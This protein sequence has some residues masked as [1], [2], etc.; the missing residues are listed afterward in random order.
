MST[1]EKAE[2]SPVADA[3]AIVRQAKWVKVAAS[4]MAGCVLVGASGALFFGRFERR[5]EADIVRERLTAVER[6]VD[7]QEA[8]FEDVLD[9]LHWQ[10]RQI[11][12]I[13][14][15]VHAERVAPPHP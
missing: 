9:E 13:G 2:S 14:D 4:L 1:A 15:A 8:H 5:S 7:V 6:K 12:K 10:R 3:R 11:E